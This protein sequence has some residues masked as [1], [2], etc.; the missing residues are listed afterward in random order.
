MPPPDLRAVA[1]R[2]WIWIGGGAMWLIAM[3]LTLARLHPDTPANQ[4]VTPWNAWWFVPP[5]VVVA[6]GVRIS[7]RDWRCPHCGRL[8]KTRFP[9]PSD[10]PG[11]GRDLWL[12][13]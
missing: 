5:I 10:C 7:Y 13:R 9:I 12:S 3:M 1:R 2:I 11:C 8:L 4:L 6:I